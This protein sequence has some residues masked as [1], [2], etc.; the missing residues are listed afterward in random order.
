MRNR[1]RTP[2]KFEGAVCRVGA[3]LMA[4]SR[5]DFGNVLTKETEKWGKLVKFSGAKPVL[6][7]KHVADTLS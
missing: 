5:T 6:S 3:S 7:W 4:G 2:A 1:N